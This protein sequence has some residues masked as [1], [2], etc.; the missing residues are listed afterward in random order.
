[1]EPTLDF[2][3]CWRAV[4]AR[5][6]RFDGR[7]FTGVTSTGI[8]CRPVCPARTPRRENVTFHP[9]AAAAEAAGFR[10]CLR[11]RPETAPDM[12]AWRGTSNT[13]G[14]ALALIEG[15][16][17][18]GA[19]VDALATR[20]GVG[21]RH[22]R[23]LFRQHLGAAPVS[24]AQT[25]RVLLAK[26]LIHE[27]RLSMAEVALA[28]G[29]GSVRRF[30]E[31][32][33]AL[34]D[35]PPSALRRRRAPE[36]TGPIRLG[37]AYRPPYDWEA[38]LAALAA[39]GDAVADGGWRRELQPDIDGT[40]GRV[41]VRAGEVGRLMVEAQVGTLSALPGV[42]ARVRRVFDLA[43]DPEAIARD[44]SADPALAAAVAAHPGL[45]LPGNWIDEADDPPSDRLS[46][47]N[48]V[49]SARAE[50]WRPWRS[51]GALYW[52]LSKEARDAQAT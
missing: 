24:V 28:S 12:G 21:E 48:P 32:F 31:A 49:L 1:M 19:D 7:F 50:R 33:Q 6:A 14:R 45:R 27:S 34:Y 4:V 36:A 43:A 46:S 51:Y 37:L 9:G 38:M 17:L 16:A 26:Q 44:L 23:R 15:G 18:D 10:A 30:N 3:A 22:L 25:R 20:L 8:Y 29:F 39:R 35:R 40:D 11:C 42:L 13:V 47:E 41:E 5:D 2:E 52:T